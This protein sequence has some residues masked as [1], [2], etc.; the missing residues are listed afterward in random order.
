M[1]VTAVI[2]EYNPFHKGHKLQLESI[3]KDGGYVVCIMS[4][5]FV[6]RG[7][8]AL[9]GKYER[10]KAAVAEGADL[11][12]E[13][14]YPYSC[15][16]AEFFCRGGVSIAHSLGIVDELCFGS[17]SGDIKLLESVGNKLSSPE[18]IAEMKMMRKDK[19][20]KEKPYAVLREEVYYNLY[21]ERLPTQ[22]NDILG[23][24]Y[25]TALKSL[26]SSIIPVTYKREKGW[27]ATESRRLISEENSLEAIPENAA[28]IFK[29]SERY[30]MKNAERAILSYYRF[31][32]AK[33]L[34]RY[35][36]MTN[37]IAG[38][39]VKSALIST[40]LDEFADNIKGKPY[41][42]AK[43]NRCIVN[44]MVGIT[45]DMMAQKPLYSQVLAFNGDG[46]SLIKQI[47]KCGSIELLT[48]PAHYKKLSE[49]ARKQAEIS[50]KAD[51]LLTLVCD[52][53]KAADYFVKQSPY[54]QK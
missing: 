13:L 27:S 17:E 42:N 32:D 37:G 9:Y 24:E 48:K 30:C 52:G 6:Q 43:I 39:M 54:M 29:N 38:R 20:A 46:R 1:K 18:F 4:G 11:V 15:S 49:N 33:Q 8:P 3:K 44:G 47:Q 2:C 23:I 26:K 45:P 31:A 34:E 36:G 35:D 50:N 12:I 10:A 53:A 40:T 14:P 19:S 5:G 22:P 28:E 41:T 51:N 21:G 25:I 7:L 16:A